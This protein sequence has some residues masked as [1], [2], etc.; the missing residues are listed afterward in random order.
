MTR[1]PN[2]TG[3]WSSFEYV[4]YLRQGH[5]DPGGIGRVDPADLTGV[6]ARL[7][8]RGDETLGRARIDRDEQSAGRL[9]IEGEQD[10][11]G[12]DTG[13]D[14]TMDAGSDSPIDA[15]IDVALDASFDAEDGE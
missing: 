4:V 11:G 15:P 12:I 2:W 1:G 5:Q 7:T 10:R 14:A 9:R 3:R 6:D 8:H 13:I